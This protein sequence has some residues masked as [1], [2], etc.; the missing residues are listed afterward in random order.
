MKI[1]IFLSIALFSSCTAKNFPDYNQLGDLRVLEIQS[2]P[3]EVSPGSSVLMTPLLS[4]LNGSGRALSYTAEACNDP[5]VGFGASPSCTGSASFTSIAGT[6]VSIPSLAGAHNTYTGA[7]PSFSVTVPTGI[8]SSISPL[9]QANGVAY[10]VVY[11][12]VASDGARVDSFKRILVSTR[13]SKGIN[14]VI[15]GVQGSGVSLMT[16]SPLPVS[17]VDLVPQFTSGLG[18]PFTVTA[19]DGSTSTTPDSLTTTWFI[20]D[21]STTYFRTI[22][23]G[24]NSWTPPGAEPANRGIVLVAVSRNNHGGVGFFQIEF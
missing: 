12:L 14:P 22:D 17:S 2:E 6:P 20:S 15:G 24:S 9:D 11:H 13:V 7:A 8:F 4:D 18:Q 1:F 19:A 21:G 10:L 3:P 23:A 16:G 5:G